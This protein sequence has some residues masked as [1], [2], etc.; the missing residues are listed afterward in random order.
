MFTER[1][2]SERGL[3]ASLSAQLTKSSLVRPGRSR[4]Q[5]EQLESRQMLAQTVADF[6]LMDVNES[7][8]TYDQPVSPR[9]FVGEV[10]GWYFGHST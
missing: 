4:C 9:D 3:R 10:S 8:S 7:S 2:K 5:F 6:G 1:S